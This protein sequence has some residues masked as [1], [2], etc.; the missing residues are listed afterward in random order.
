MKKLF[1]IS[2]MLFLFTNCSKDPD[3][4]NTCTTTAANI[5]GSY[6][7][8]ASTYKETPTS[9][10]EDLMATMEPCEKD[11]LL[12]FKTDGT[13]ETLD[14]AIVCTPPNDEIGDWN[15]SGSTLVVDGEPVTIKS[16]NCKTLVLVT[17]EIFIPGDQLTLTLQKQ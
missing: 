8:S 1:P 6:K 9:D 4:N 14:A 17:S 10:E 13:Y 11:D 3:D 5:A 12:T 16:F 15:L 2:L 7:V